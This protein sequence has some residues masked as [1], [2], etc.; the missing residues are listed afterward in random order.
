MKLF[1]GLMSGTSMD[2]IDA[3]LIDFETNE[4]IAVATYPYSPELKSDLEC[5]VSNPVHS[6]GYFTQ[7]STRI[8]KEFANA[9][10]QLLDL[11]PYNSADVIAIG[12]HGQTICHDTSGIIPYTVQLGCAH[13]IAEKTKIQVIADFRTRDLVNGGQGAPFAP[14]YHQ[15]LFKAM[16]YPLAIVNVGGISNITLLQDSKKVIGFDTGPGNCLMDIWIKHHLQKNFDNNGQWAARGQVLPDLLN[17]LLADEFFKKS[18]PKSIGKEYFSLD[19]LTNFLSLSFQPEDVQATLLQLTAITIADAIKKREQLN[20]IKIKQLFVCGGGA[21][22]QHLLNALSAL[23]PTIKVASTD[24]IGIN[25][26]YIEALMVAWLAFNCF[27]GIALD[28]TCITGANHSSILGVIY[29]AGL[30][31]GKLLRCNEP[32]LKKDYL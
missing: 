14:I 6:L 15:T 19:W 27:E 7:L 26:D 20:K 22:N 3:A 21:H 2:G 5:I 18:E 24:T 4:L 8:G 10:L 31:K 25:P 11:T 16:S 23:L 28:L 1:M 32:F 30:D 9:S 12:S 13:T 17:S 29:P